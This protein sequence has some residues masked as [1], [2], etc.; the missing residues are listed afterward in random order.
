MD[1]FTFLVKSLKGEHIYKTARNGCLVVFF[2]IYNKKCKR[3]QNIEVK[4]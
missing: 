1:N 2:Y 4:E 3:K